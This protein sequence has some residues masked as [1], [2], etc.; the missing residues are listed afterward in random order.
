M[1]LNHLDLYAIEGMHNGLLC[2]SLI[3][4]D[5]LVVDYDIDPITVAREYFTTV[6]VDDFIAAVVF[7][8]A[9]KA[10]L[11]VYRGEMSQD[12]DYLLDV[13]DK[14][15]KNHQRLAELCGYMPG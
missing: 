8:L 2:C 3:N 14:L 12:Q 1:D 11:Q 9:G 4:I 10:T 13:C 5:G 6:K 15:K 7:F